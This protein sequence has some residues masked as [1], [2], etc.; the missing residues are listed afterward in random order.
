MQVSPYH[1]PLSSC[2]TC[3]IDSTRPIGSPVT[4]SNKAYG[5]SQY[6][7]DPELAHSSK[8]E[9]FRLSKWPVERNP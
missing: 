5:C 7:L 4:T 2:L 9:R 8:C 6:C 3:V 1:P